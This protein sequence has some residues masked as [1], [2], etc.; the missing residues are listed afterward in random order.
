[1]PSDQHPATGIDDRLV[2][3]IGGAGLLAMMLMLASW[4]GLSY[5]SEPGMNGMLNLW[6]VLGAALPLVLGWWGAAAGYGWLICRRL[7]PPSKSHFVIQLGLGA[8]LL[9]WLEAGLGRLGV[10]QWGGNWGGWMLFLGGWIALTFPLVRMVKENRNYGIPNPGVIWTAIP[11]L[12]VLLVASGSAP[13]WLW[14]TEFG[15]Y[16]ALSYHLQL[17]KEWLD[18]GR[19]TILEHNI[20]SALP[21]YMEGAFYHLMTLKGDAIEAAYS[22]QLLHASFGLA[23]A[24]AIYELGKKWMGRGRGAIAAVLLL[25]TPWV[26][27]TGSLAYNELAVTLFLVTGLLVLEEDRLIDI[28]WAILVGFLAGCACGAKLTAIGFVA[29]PLLILLLHAAPRRRWLLMLVIMGAT[30]LLAGLPYLLG[31]WLRTGNPVFPFAASWLGYGHWTPD[32]VAIWSGAHGNDLSLG[33]R[34]IEVWNQWV[35]YGLGTNPYER[36]G[37]PWQP[38]WSILPWLT[39]AG[40]LVGL[41]RSRLRVCTIKI[42]IIL[43]V[44]FVF[45]IFFT[46]IKSRFML[47]AVVPCALA[48]GMLLETIST[49]VPRR[50]SGNALSLVLLIYASLSIWIFKQEKGE[51]PAANIGLH[52]QW[53]D[54]GPHGLKK[55]LLIG[56]ATPYYYQFPLSYQTTW[57]RGILSRLM[58]D[59]PDDPA[60]WAAEL[61]NMGYSHLIVDAGMLENWMQKGWNDPNLTPDR[62]MS[63]IQATT[64]PSGSITN[65]RVYELR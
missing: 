47:P 43:M 16:D 45:W 42:L 59:Y 49:T 13:G 62:V 44:Q 54:N 15:G 18:L 22:C 32:Q 40:L 2:W 7:F 51:H 21:S 48:A 35:R 23:T 56:D 60:R 11:A 24:I 10:L 52:H 38:Q 63:F 3:I 26:V 50:F 29:I 37:E 55:A 53:I 30:A 20:Y 57:D 5:G 36:A 41:I 4:D 19:I 14:A 64:E 27:V 61:K 46:H 33:N 9:M 39:L 28:P 12:A 17:P 8:A 31:N 58:V 1:M 6:W 65:S 34:G 25:G